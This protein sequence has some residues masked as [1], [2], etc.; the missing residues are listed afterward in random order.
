MSKF[1]GYASG[2]M[3]EISLR[4]ILINYLVSENITN[5]RI[6]PSYKTYSY[7]LRKHADIDLLVIAECGL[8]AIEMKAY[9]SRVIGNYNEKMWKGITF[10]SCTMFFNPVFQ[11]KEHIRSLNT[12]LRRNGENT[13][14]IENLVCVPNSC[15]LN[16]D[17]KEV[18]N[19]SALISKLVMDIKY[20]DKI[21]N[22][23]KCLETL[24]RLSL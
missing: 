22:V 7:K 4:N 24:I 17:C 8:Y 12:V 2:T 19:E 15:V 20:K 1:S 11:N 9:K 21:I 14:P 3:H 6:I 10:K 23:D 16:T 5:F 13:F 18:L